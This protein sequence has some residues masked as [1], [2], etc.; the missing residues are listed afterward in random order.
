MACARY[1]TVELPGRAWGQRITDL[2]PDLTA[3]AQ[4]LTERPQR[5]LG[6]LTRRGAFEHQLI[7]GEVACAS[8]D[9]PV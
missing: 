1:R 3:I 9:C 5:V 4:E 7:N 2:Q 8:C 6:Y